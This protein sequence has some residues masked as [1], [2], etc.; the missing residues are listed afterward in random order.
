MTYPPNQPFPGSDPNQPGSSPY[1]GP[2]SAPGSSPYGT[3]PVAP[4]GTPPGGAPYGP[5]GAAGGPPSNNIGWA[6]AAIFLCWPFAIPAFI[7]SGKVDNLWR[8]GDFAGAQQAS[9]DAK[10]WGSIGVYVGI[11]LTVLG[12]L[13][14]IGSVILGASGS[15]M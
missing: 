5:G 2:P 11:G 3:P 15:N 9:A 14:G 1:A 6:I 8:Q 4:Y 13:C 7:A 10:K 12:C